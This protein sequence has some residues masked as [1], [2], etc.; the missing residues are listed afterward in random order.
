M[1][2]LINALVGVYRGRSCRRCAGAIHGADGFAMSEGVCRA[3]AAVTPPL[4]P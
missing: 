2:D 4:L 3:C 1:F